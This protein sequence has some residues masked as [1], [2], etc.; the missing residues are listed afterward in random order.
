MRIKITSIVGTR[1]ELIR[2]AKIFSKFDKYFDHRIIHTGQNNTHEL[3]DIF[4]KDLHIRKPDF[5]FNM[6]SNNLGKSLSNLFGEMGEEFINNKPD[7]IVVLGDTNSSLCGI[8]AKRLQIPFYHIEAGLRSFDKNVPEEINR[9]IIDH[10]ADFNMVYTEQART[11]L[12]N[13][14]LHPRTISLIGS[15][16]KEVISENMTEILESKILEKLDINKNEFYLVSLHRQENV[17]NTS[18]LKK[19][20]VSLNN[21]SLD[22]GLPIIF[23]MHPRTKNEVKEMKLNLNSNVKF[24]EPFGFNDYCKL[25]L[26]SRL[27]LSDSGSVSEEAAIL[28]FKAITLR[29]SMERPEA[30]ESGSIVMSGANSDMLAEY[31]QAVE[32]MQIASHTP[33]EYK[34]SDTSERVVKFI[35]STIH[36]YNFW[37][38]IRKN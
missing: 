35:L 36:Q 5:E 20:M 13:E 9:R 1:P 30:L 33:I 24:Y 7:A 21:L 25:Q 12:L 34:I 22:T 38:G 31:V 14:G 16:M 26:N 23:S 2:M 37:F 32:S 29:D 3:K 17:N 11:N 10:T 15:P 18:R 19:I 6:N 27:V 28:G 4:F 8:L